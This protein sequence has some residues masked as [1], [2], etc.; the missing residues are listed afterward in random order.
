MRKEGEDEE[1]GNTKEEDEEG[2]Q[3]DEKLE[4]DNNDEDEEEEGEDEEQQHTK[5]IRGVVVG[6]VG[7]AGAPRA[8]RDPLSLARLA[9]AKSIAHAALA[10]GAPRGNH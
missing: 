5:R 3:E 10:P 4:E 7:L 8:L 9:R 1:Q 6:G 2:E